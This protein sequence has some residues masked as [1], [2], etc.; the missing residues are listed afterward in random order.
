MLAGGPGQAALESFPQ[1]AAAFRGI[2]RDRDVILVDQRGTGRSHA[3]HCPEAEADGDGRP[4][5]TGCC[6]AVD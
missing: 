6:A 2:L 3:L 4:H 1:V 5:G